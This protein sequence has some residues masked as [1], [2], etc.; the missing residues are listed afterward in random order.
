[1]NEAASAFGQFLLA[2]QRANIDSRWLMVRCHESDRPES[3]DD[4][5]R[6][7]VLE[8]MQG[9]S[10][11][12]LTGLSDDD[13]FMMLK[14]C[15]LVREKKNRWGTNKE[16]QLINFKRY[17][18]V[19][20]LTDAESDV[21][22]LA[23][24]SKESYYLRVGKRTSNYCTSILNQVKKG[25][26]S[27]PRIPDLDHLRRKLRRAILGL[28]S[29]EDSSPEGEP[30]TSESEDESATEDATPSVDEKYP[31]LKD[32]GIDTIFRKKTMPII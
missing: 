8:R 19:T 30:S 13:Y 20:G 17:L 31:L 22:K 21:A 28:V 4:P 23:G 9:I 12:A 7:S 14:E 3:V 10:L 1:M 5:E 2:I 25:I 6:R 16:F 24:F 26:F 32:L 29:T 11:Q 18:L 15:E 27:V